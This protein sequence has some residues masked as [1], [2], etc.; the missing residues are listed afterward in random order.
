DEYR[1]CRKARRGT[2]VAG[3]QP[4]IHKKLIEPEPTP[5]V[6]GLLMQERPVSEPA[7]RPGARL[8][9]YRST[10]GKLFRSQIDVQPHFFV[11]VTIEFSAPEHHDEAPAQFL[12]PQHTC[13]PLSAG[14]EDALNGAKYPVE[15]RHFRLELFSPKLCNPVV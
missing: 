14:L 3:R 1:E 11:K 15:L 4:E 13:R 8:A 7:S 5:L 9:A 2:Q 12:D 6:A 10:S